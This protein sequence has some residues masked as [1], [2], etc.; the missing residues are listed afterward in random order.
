MVSNHTF[1]AEASAGSRDGQGA[2]RFA[3]TPS[4]DLHVGNLRTALLAW[5]FARS[6][7][8]AFVLR[9]DD[10]DPNR[11]RVDVVSAQI[12]DLA[13]IG[14]T[15]DRIEER[16]AT[17]GL[18]DEQHVGRSIAIMHQSERAGAYEEALSEL[19]E[20]GMVY[21]CYCSRREILEA[22]TA[23]HALPGAYPGTCRYLTEAERAERRRVRPHPALR[24]RAEVAEFTVHDALHGEVAGQVDDF[25]LMRGD[26][27][28][29]YNLAVVVDDAAQ[30]VDQVVRGDDLLASTSRQAYLGTLLGLPPVEYAHVP[31]VLSPSGVRL[32]KR[33]GAVTLARLADLGLDAS[34]VTGLMLTSLGLPPNLVDALGVFSPE[35]LPLVPWV[36]TPPV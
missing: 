30:G 20:R 13:M 27:T 17:C 8:R 23:A 6:T 2:G 21:E 7:G 14:V 11:S 1:G 36:F 32:A 15:F 24:L 28:A 9:I 4:G 5:L 22:P 33:D 19:R 31:L 12:R 16:R 25:V 29:A 3:P 34:V 35:A 10:L 18:A 26:G